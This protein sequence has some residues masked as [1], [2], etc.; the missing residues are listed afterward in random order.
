MS[1]HFKMAVLGEIVPE[2]SHYVLHFSKDIQNYLKFSS[3]NKGIL[4]I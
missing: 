1:T 2:A 4:C 3:V